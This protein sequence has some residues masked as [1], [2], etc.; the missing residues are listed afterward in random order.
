M[1]SWSDI[2]L[3]KV[4]PTLEPIAVGEYV[5]TLSGAKYDKNDPDKINAQAVIAGDGEFSGKHTFFSY[6]SPEV[7]ADSPKLLARL[8][9][10]LGIDAVPGEDPVAYLNRASGGQ[11]KARIK[12]AVDKN[13]DTVIYANLNIF[14]VKAA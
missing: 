4:N 9:I 12:H 14:S 6:P 1:S 11:F 3:T 5:F 13:D 2:D 10:A 7:L 8:M